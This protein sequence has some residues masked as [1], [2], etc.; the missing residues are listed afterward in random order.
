MTSN[1]DLVN[2][3]LNRR[4]GIWMKLST[5]NWTSGWDFARMVE[6][7]DSQTNHHFTADQKK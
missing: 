1:R 7:Q 6:Y 4:L 2:G 3:A 5:I